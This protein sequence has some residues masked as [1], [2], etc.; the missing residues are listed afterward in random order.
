[1][2]VVAR[3]S[4]WLGLGLRDIENAGGAPF[5]ARRCGGRGSGRRRTLPSSFPSPVAL[6]GSYDP[7]GMPAIGYIS[8]HMSHFADPQMKELLITPRGTRLVRQIWQAERAHFLVLRQAKFEGRSVEPSIL[9]SL[10]DAA[11][12]ISRSLGA[13]EVHLKV[14]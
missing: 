10:L 14:A 12:D 9:A 13:P 2:F 8:R 1:M 4:P 11:I 3:N 5:G 7:E 6:L